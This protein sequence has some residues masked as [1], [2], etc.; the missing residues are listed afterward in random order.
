MIRKYWLSFDWCGQAKPL[1]YILQH[2]S[3]CSL[4]G[5]KIVNWGFEIGGL[6]VPMVTRAAL[7][8]EMQALLVM[9]LQC[10]CRWTATSTGEFLD[11]KGNWVLQERRAVAFKVCI[12][13]IPSIISSSFTPSHSL[14]TAQYQKK[15]GTWST[16]M[17]ISDR[18]SGCG[19]RAFELSVFPLML[20]AVPGIL[21]CTSMWS[22]DLWSYFTGSWGM[23]FRQTLTY[24][25]FNRVT[26][27]YQCL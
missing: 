24:L 17:R 8:W 6:P 5:S 18:L 13:L 2:M 19:P 12:L 11:I 20:L 15:K 27:A 10:R 21:L 4:T 22:Q 25:V 7:N 1:L 14:Q 9:R 3:I 16:S 26:F 23:Q